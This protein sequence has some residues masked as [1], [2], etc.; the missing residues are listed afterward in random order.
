V[1][2][3]AQAACFGFEK[4]DDIVAVVVVLGQVEEL[5]WAAKQE[6]H[7]SMYPARVAL[8]LSA[9]LAWKTSMLSDEAVLP[10]VWF[11]IAQMLI[12]KA[13]VC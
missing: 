6:R 7:S 11:R 9:F 1:S 4:P 2:S 3:R 5:V 13:L 12:S 10:K 8:L